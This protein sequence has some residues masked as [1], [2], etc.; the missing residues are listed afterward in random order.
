MP[1]KAEAASVVVAVRV[2]PV[3]KTVRNPIVRWQMDI[4]SACVHENGMCG[5]AGCRLYWILGVM[6]RRYGEVR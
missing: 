3:K 1:G 5:L 6:C 4:H 2:R